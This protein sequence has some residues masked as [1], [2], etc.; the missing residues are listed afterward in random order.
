MKKQGGASSMAFSKVTVVA[1]EF[2]GLLPLSFSFQINLLVQNNKN[3][4]SSVDES[5]VFKNEKERSHLLCI[6]NPL[7]FSLKSTP[8]KRRLQMGKYRGGK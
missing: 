6:A 7:S 4:N 5:A 2:F 8:N 3:C 1:V